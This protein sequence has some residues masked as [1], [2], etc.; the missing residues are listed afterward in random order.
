MRVLDRACGSLSV[1]VPAGAFDELR[2]LYHRLGGDGAA[3][4][5]PGDTCPDNNVLVDGRLVLLDFENAQWRH[6]AWDVAYLRVPWP[7]CRCSWRMPHDVVDRAVAAYRQAA[8]AAFPE[9]AAPAFE[10]DLEAATVGL[11]LITATWFLD[12]AFGAEPALPDRDLNAPSR[13]AVIMNRLE[14]ASRSTELP[15]LA[16]LA[17]SLVGELRSRWGTVELAV[18]PAFR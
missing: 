7:S 3:A 2:E 14:N 11:A 17:Q 5:T 15:A 6:V 13:R 1:A 9:G 16:E 10:R 8:A 4:I 12:D 18:A